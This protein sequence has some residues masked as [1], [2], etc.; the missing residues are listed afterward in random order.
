MTGLSLPLGALLA[1]GLLVSM[2]L[3]GTLIARLPMS[4]AVIYLL[5]GWLLGLAGWPQWQLAQGADSAELESLTEV[6]L[7]ISLFGVGLRLDLPWR[8]PR[9]RIPLWLAF[10]GMA[11]TVALIAAVAMLGLGWPP[12]P[13]CLLGAILAPTDPVLASEIQSEPGQATD[14]V[15]FSLSGEG[16]ANDGSAFPFVLL[17]LA[18]LLPGGVNASMFW[19]WWWRDLLWATAG[20]L[21]AGVL[22]GA[23]VGRLLVWLRVRHG[24]ALG[25]EAFLA[26]GVIGLSYGGARLL[27]ASGFLAVFAAGLA[28]RR[29]GE[30]GGG[31]TSPLQRRKG[32]ERGVDGQTSAAMKEAVLAFIEQLEKCAELALVLVLGM[33]LHQVHWFPAL[34]WFVPLLLVVLRPLAVFCATASV[35]LAAR[36]R[37]LLAWFGVRGIGSLYYLVY[38]RNHGALGTHADALVTLTLV[39]V[40]ASIL[41]HGVTAQ[42][43]MRLYEMDKR[44]G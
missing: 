22:V 28:L 12:G 38:A 40:A 1:G 26:L 20:G 4:A 5:A 36:Q 19:S 16:G 30:Q 33:L 9:W 10:P 6:A 31:Q 43:L 17:G 35:A 42:P 27:H 7:L 32:E 8:D 13:A 3:I 24:M 29:V 44:A 2:V 41:L 39:T 18:W 14:S 11:L 15:R 23:G 25:Q 37:L 34:G 21:A